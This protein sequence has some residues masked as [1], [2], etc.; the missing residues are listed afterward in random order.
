MSQFIKNIEVLDSGSKSFTELKLYEDS[1]E[2]LS[3]QSAIGDTI[4]PSLKQFIFICSFAHHGQALPKDLD[5][6]KKIFIKG[7]KEDIYGDL[8]KIFIRLH[9]AII[10]R[11]LKKV[12]R[13]LKEMEEELY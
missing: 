5:K 11:D 13:A 12:E 7:L 8:R 9:Q 2:G 10:E 3:N 1:P 6:A 4:Y